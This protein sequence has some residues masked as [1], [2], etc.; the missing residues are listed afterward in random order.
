M[1]KE[2]EALADAERYAINLRNTE[3]RAEE[4]AKI[5]KERGGVATEKGKTLAEQQKLLSDFQRLGTDLNRAKTIDEINAQAT[6]LADTL[7]KS[8]AINIQQRDKLLN[9]IKQITD[10]QKKKEFT[11][12][13]IRWGLGATG[14]VG[15]G[16]AYT[17]FKGQ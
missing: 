1:L 12:K 15:A 11:Q 3:K 10:L 16:S 5:A 7:E 17:A 13:V 8:G 9:D 14:A 2:T 6:K 4:A